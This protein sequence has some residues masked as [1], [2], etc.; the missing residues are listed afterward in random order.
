MKELYR[1]LHTF[2]KYKT[3]TKTHLRY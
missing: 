1:L 3:P 2:S